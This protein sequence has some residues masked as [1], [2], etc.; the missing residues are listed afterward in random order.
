MQAEL[1]E[2][3]FSQKL[4][5]VERIIELERTRQITKDEIIQLSDSCSNS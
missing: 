5:A 4:A 1:A 3:N 2:E